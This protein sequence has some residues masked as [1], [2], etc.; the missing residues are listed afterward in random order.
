VDPPQRLYERPKRQFVAEF[1][2]SP[3]MNLIP[4]ELQSRGG[5]VSAVW[6]DQR[7]RVPDLET[8]A[9][10]DGAL[11]GV[12]PETLSVADEADQ[13][14]LRCDVEVTE[15]LGDTLLVHG[16]T[17]GAS[18]RVQLPPHADVTEGQSHHFRCDPTRMHLFDADSGDVLYQSGADEPDRTSATTRTDD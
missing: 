14:T 8:D 17:G 15:S 12:R 11:L 6:A 7:L 4:V 10:R 2:G 9:A 13:Y 3:S 1:I 5:A 18:V 16:R